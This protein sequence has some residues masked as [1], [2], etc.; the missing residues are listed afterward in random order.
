VSYAADAQGASADI[1]AAGAPVVFTRTTRTYDP[2]AG[3]SA[4]TVATASSVAITRIPTGA[5][6]ERMKALELV[7]LKAVVLIVA[8]LSLGSFAPAPLDVVTWAGQAYTVRDVSALGP[9]GVTPILYFVVA[10]R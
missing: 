4:Q 7:N 3:E 10:A 5:D 9:D 1:A 6:R 8:G 2:V